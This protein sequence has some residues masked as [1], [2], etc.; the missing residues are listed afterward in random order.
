LAYAAAGEPFDSGLQTA[1]L[2]RLTPGTLGKASSMEIGAFFIL[3]I[4]VGV[5]AVIGGFVYAIAT[6]LRHKQLDAAG[7]LVEDPSDADRRPRPE[8]V[9]VETEQRTRFVGTR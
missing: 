5:V 9:E 6:R 4:V 2:G 7:D 1:A 3:V 8:H